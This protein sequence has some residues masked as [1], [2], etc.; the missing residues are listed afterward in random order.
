MTLEEIE[1]EYR[2]LKRSQLPDIFQ[3]L[4]FELLLEIARE[5]QTLR[6]DYDY[7]NKIAEG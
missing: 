3:R 6:A 2:Q 1:K 7:V 4:Q 5:L